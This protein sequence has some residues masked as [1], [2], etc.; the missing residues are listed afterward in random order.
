M[1]IGLS[2]V[3]LFAAGVLTRTLLR[4]MTDSPGFDPR[5]LLTVK[6]SLPRARY[7]SERQA[8]FFEAARV[9]LASI[10]GVVASAAVY[11]LP[12]SGEALEVGV[13]LRGQGGP[14]PRESS[15]RAADQ[16]SACIYMVTPQYFGTMRIPIIR[17][18]EF[19]NDDT[20]SSAAV[21]VVG[22]EFARRAFGPENPIG[23]RIWPGIGADAAPGGREIVGVVG[24]VKAAEIARVLTSQV[25]VP[26][27][28]LPTNTM[29]VMVR[30]AVRPMSL[31]NSVR[32]VVLDMDPEVPVFGV[33]SMEDYLGMTVAEPRFTAA[34]TN[35]FAL[36]ALMLTAVGIYGVVAQEVLERRRELSVRA[37]LGAQEGDL[38]RG[39]L[40]RGAALTVLGLAIG[41]A[42]VLAAGPLLSG[43]AFAARP[44]DL[45]TIAAVVLI[46]MALGTVCSYIP[47]ARV[48]RCGL[49]GNLRD[50]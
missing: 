28:Q 25:Y 13:D 7:S 44:F 31:A 22:E 11:P 47:A 34:L 50:Q 5:G 3:V 23:K 49:L 27:A 38:I 33:H 1:Q 42:G 46:V 8:R 24:D 26:L 39:V 14:V 29:A 37:A 43:L 19:R 32:G 6:M 16:V 40:R 35:S 9:R 12:L 15:V 41:V 17:G 20:R 45:E 2:V 30:S 10:P 18:R 4:L 36:L 21:A 48:V